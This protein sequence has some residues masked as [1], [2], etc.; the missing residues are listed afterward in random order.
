MCFTEI[1][2]ISDTI[3]SNLYLLFN[4]VRK[5]IGIEN[6]SVLILHSHKK[7]W[8]NTICSNVDGPR[9]YCTKWP[10]SD[11]ERQILY[12]I[13]YMCKVR[14]EVIYKIETYRHRRQT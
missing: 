5:V 3:V 1:F 8:N 7:E 6:S 13:T 11:R 2:Y 9:E 14:N 4:L 12:D 10:K